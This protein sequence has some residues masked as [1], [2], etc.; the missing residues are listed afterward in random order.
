V[1]RCPACSRVVLDTPHNDD[2][3]AC[4]GVVAFVPPD[5]APEPDA[6]A[7]V[8]AEPVVVEVQIAAAPPPEK[9]TP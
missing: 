9:A 4:Y 2:G 3:R 5:P 7:L 1:I 8:V 6:L